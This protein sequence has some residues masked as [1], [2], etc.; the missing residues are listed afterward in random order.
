MDSTVGPSYSS[1]SAVPSRRAEALSSRLAASALA[2][3]GGVMSNEAF[4]AWFEERQRIHALQVRRIPFG[5]LRGWGFAP[6]SGN[7]RHDSGRFFSIEGLRVRSD[8]GPVRDWC[9]PIIH[10]PEIGVLGIAVREIDGLLHCLMQAKP[11]P[12][13][14]NGV[15]LSPTVQATKSNYTRVHGGSAVPY[16][17]C[18]VDPDPRRV[19]ADVL[20]SEQGSWFY[21]KR[22]RNMVV[23]V[24]PGVEAGEDFCWVTLGQ[25]G[26][27]LR[28]PD[29]V[30]MDARTVLS[31]FPDWRAGS[32]MANAGRHSD[33]EIRSWLTTRRARHE[34]TTEPL[35][36]GEAE[37]WRRSQDAISHESGRFFSIVAVD[38][39]SHRREVPAWSQPLL[40]P[41]GLGM[42]ALLVKRIGGVPH[43]LLSARVEP[44]FRDVVELGPTVQCTPDSYA[45]LPA[46]DRPRF[47][48][49]VQEHR[50]ERTLFDAVLSEEGGRFLCARS[51][52][53]IVEVGEDFPTEAPEEFHWVTP[54]QIN[55]LLKY[56]HH[57]NVQARTLV[58]GMRTLD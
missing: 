28:R 45:A 42:A 5:E 29:L 38:V 8:Y 47:L 54:C 31:C 27:L 11:E 12:G 17:E 52:Y 40:E 10:Q 23:E 57:L 35:P 43:A 2:T 30:N 18:F 44:G 48:D 25:L 19:L 9:Q 58:A 16:M 1:G 37:G 20:Q 32:S 22:N 6:G 56:S 33:T 4:H 13:N 24:G 39:S 53:L 3:E 15:Q 26:A 34:I 36:L 55:E 21:Q 7:L 49:V 41:H 14:A 46:G 50:P 51:R